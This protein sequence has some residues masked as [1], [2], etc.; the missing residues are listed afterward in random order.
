MN[1]N[2]IKIIEVLSNNRLYF[3][4]IAKLTN[5]KS[6]NNLVKNLSLMVKTGIPV[7]GH[8]LFYA[9]YLDN[10]GGY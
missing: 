2:S 9:K 1:K 5:I 8:V 6:K 10:F 3:N 7:S 4:Q